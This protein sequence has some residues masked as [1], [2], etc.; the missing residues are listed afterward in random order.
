MMAF[1]VCVTG[2]SLAGSYSRL[3]TTNRG[4]PEQPFRKGLAEFL[5]VRTVRKCV[6][7]KVER[8][9]K[10]NK[11]FNNNNNNNNITN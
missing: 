10:I 8:K 4:H 2:P 11:I 6:P 1:L 5:P 3:I 7:E 9:N